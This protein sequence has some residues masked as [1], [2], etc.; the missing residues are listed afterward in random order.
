M[1]ARQVDSPLLKLFIL[2]L[3]YIILVSLSTLKL[4]PVYS[5]P[6]YR[7]G[8]SILGLKLPPYRQVNGTK[9]AVYPKHLEIVVHKRNG[10]KLNL[11]YVSRATTY[12]ELSSELSRKLKMDLKTVPEI[13]GRGD[14]QPIYRVKLLEG[15]RITLDL[16]NQRYSMKVF[17]DS[18]YLLLR[19]LSEKGILSNE[20]LNYP[21]LFNDQSLEE[22]IRELL[23]R[24][25]LKNSAWSYKFLK[26][27]ISRDHRI[28]SGDLV[29]VALYEVKVSRVRQE[30]TPETKYVYS[31]SQP[32]GTQKVVSR[33]EPGILESLSVSIARNGKLL[34]KE[35]LRSHWVKQPKPRVILIGKGV[36]FQIEDEEERFKGKPYIIVEATAYEPS[37]LSCGPYSDGY[38]ALG[39]KVRKGI[40]A[41]DPEVIP[42]GTKLYVQGYG[43]AIAGDVGGAIK[44]YRIDV[45]FPTY[46]EAINWGRRRVKVYIIE[47]PKGNPRDSYAWLLKVRGDESG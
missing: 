37:S 4:Y 11:D 5:P 26:L 20:Y 17:S 7:I 13:I 22:E 1:R 35:L 16:L 44:G 38:T 18:P 24:R 3:I 34:R 21:I 41:V 30:I 32:I 31:Y 47:L 14:S 15:R 27:S 2:S 10:E 29:I 25:S 23:K 12:R 46:Q 9:V 45:F 39:L 43:W 8:I 36:R 6:S 40:V 33:G 19:E 42:L 28:K